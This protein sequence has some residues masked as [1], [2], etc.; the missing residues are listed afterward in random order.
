LQDDYVKFIRFAQWRIEST[1]HGILGF[2]TNH[3][4]LDNPTFRGMRQNLMQ[5]FSEI[6]VYDLHGNTKKP[7]VSPDGRPDE[8]VFDIQQGVAIIL[9]VK[10][11][12]KEGLANVYH[13][14]L[15]GLRE[16]KYSVLFDEDVTRTKWTPLHPTT[17]NYFFFPQVTDLKAEY[18]NNWKLTEAMPLNVTGFQT[19]RDP[20]AIAFDK[21]TIV[22]RVERLRD[23]KD[24]DDELREL[25][26]LKDSGE[27]RLADVRAALRK[28]KEWKSAFLECF[29]RPFDKRWCHYDDATMD[30]P[31][32]ELIDNMAG[33]ENLALNVCR[34]TKAPRWQHAVISDTP[35]PAVYVELKD[36][37]NVFPLYL[38]PESKQ[39]TLHAAER[40]T[41][42]SE[43]FIADLTSKLKLVW[44]DDLSG[45]LKKTIGPEDVLAYVY[46]VFNAP[47]YRTRYAEFLKR[48][49]PGLPLTSDVELLAALTAK[50]KELT[51]RSSRLK[52]AMWL[53]GSHTHPRTSRYGS[54]L[55]NILEACRKLFGNHSSE[56]IRYASSGWRTAKV[57]GSPMMTFSTGSASWLPL[58]KPCD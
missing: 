58:K 28:N 11:T 33:K 17:P 6:H 44:K 40:Q 45:D 32:R 53:K 35:A 10:T 18:E 7:E 54:T 52:V 14:D 9:A 19:H 29:Y 16:Q 48:D 20:F 27:W 51:S 22:Q 42:F 26:Q 31:R 12:T 30:R 55:C 57:E 24:S 56:G 46:A 5:S 1:G 41:N 23:N 43:K 2:V 34:Q 38:Y 3:S 37:S 50:G 21:E 49:F 39:R 47:S 8:N 36:G 15:W 13:A 4:Y 25:F